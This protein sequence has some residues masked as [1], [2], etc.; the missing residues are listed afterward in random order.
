MAKKFTPSAGKTLV[1]EC[2][3]A[4]DPAPHFGE[5]EGEELF[6]DILKVIT[7]HVI[8]EK[9]SSVATALWVLHTYCYDGFA[10]SPLLLINAPERACGKSIALTLVGYLVTRPLPVS[11]ITLAALFRV[12]N[13]RDPVVLIDEVDTFLEGK[14]EIAGLL[15]AGFSK[16]GFVLRVES[17]KDKLTEVAYVVFGPKALA[18]I[19]LERYLLASTMSRGIQVALRRKVKGE[20]VQRLRMTPPAIF[21]ELRSR[22]QKFINE[23]KDQLALGYSDLPEQLDDRSQDCWEPLFA[24]ASCIGPEVLAMAKQAALDTV[25]TT[26]KSQSV[27]N[28]LLS[29]IREVLVSFKLQ[30]ITTVDLLDKL[31]SDPDMGWDKY[32][33]G[34]PLTPRQLSQNLQP[35]GIKPKTVRVSKT[36]TPKGYEISDFQ[37]AFNR[38]LSPLE[39]PDDEFLPVE[40][41]ETSASKDLNLQLE[42][43]KT[44]VTSVPLGTSSENVGSDC[45]AGLDVSDNHPKDAE[46]SF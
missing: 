41:D 23:H 5:V 29:D 35:Y 17:V 34:F 9:H 21:A 13:N 19:A 1:D 33:K 28:N 31:V 22:I 36:Q 42:D 40:C 25:A 6:D 38:Y 26:Q 8:M 2:L 14:S 12:I 43:F 10:H 32:N 44:S 16:G 37:D 7:D 30:R 4:N 3:S 24:V 15:N 27:S 18:G 46:P 11:N 20:N 39:M 45:P